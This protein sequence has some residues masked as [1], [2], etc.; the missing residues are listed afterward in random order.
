MKKKKIENFFISIT[1]FF[2]FDFFETEKKL[3]WG[4]WVPTLA[5]VRIHI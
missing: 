2:D 4:F 1:I 3:M 5:Q